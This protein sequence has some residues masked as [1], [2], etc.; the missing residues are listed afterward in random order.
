M[1]LFF[2]PPPNLEAEVRAQRGEKKKKGKEE[3]KNRGQHEQ[4]YFSRPLRACLYSLWVFSLQT[5]SGRCFPLVGQ[6][7]VLGPPC[8]AIK[9]QR[10]LQDPRILGKLTGFW[11][12]ACPG[13]ACFGPHNPRVSVVLARSF[14]VPFVL[15]L[16]SSC[17]SQEAGG[18]EAREPPGMFLLPLFFVLSLSLPWPDLIPSFP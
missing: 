7:P 8:L 12:G 2:S 10:L 4:Q 3:E 9:G 15:S 1:S 16:S 6:D 5:L 13:T 18:R 17:S 11:E 14:L